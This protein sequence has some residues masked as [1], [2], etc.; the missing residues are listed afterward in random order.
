MRRLYVN[1]L[2]FHIKALNIRGFWSWN[3]SYVGTREQLSYTNAFFHPSFPLIHSRGSREPAREL[4]HDYLRF[5]KSKWLPPCS[6][7]LCLLLLSPPSSSI[8]SPRT[9]FALQRGDQTVSILG[10]EEDRD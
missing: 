1:A 5:P 8:T 10:G 6:S 2:A 3:Q 7:C 4:T 9:F